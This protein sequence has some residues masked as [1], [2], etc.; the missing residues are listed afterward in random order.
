[1]SEIYTREFSHHGVQYPGIHLFD[2][3]QLGL[4]T[5]WHEQAVAVAGEL[6]KTVSVRWEDPEGHDILERDANGKLVDPIHYGF[7][8]GTALREKMPWLYDAYQG[9]LLTLAQEKFGSDFAT[10][11]RD[12]DF[13][14]MLT[15]K[16]NDRSEVHA[17]EPSVGVLLYP[18]P[19]EAGGRLF[20][21]P[22]MHTRGYQNMIRKGAPIFPEVDLGIMFRGDRYVH[23]AERNLGRYDRTV[24]NLNY[25][26]KSMLNNA[27]TQ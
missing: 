25:Y 20:V 18:R 15:A 4:P 6:N 7:V 1:M 13:A 22:T 23:V 11:T 24:I 2:V 17:D 16:P 3:A 26:L 27:L 14:R 9:D 5:D 21:T 12:K 10:S 8:G 19:A